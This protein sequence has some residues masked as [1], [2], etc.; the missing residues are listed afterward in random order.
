MNQD[1]ISNKVKSKDGKYTFIEEDT[2]KIDKSF[3]KKNIGDGGACVPHILRKS[4]DKNMKKV[5][6][7]DITTTNSKCNIIRYFFVIFTFMIMNIIHMISFA[8]WI[9]CMIGF[10]YPNGQKYPDEELTNFELFILI[11]SNFFTFFTFDPCAYIFIP[12]VYTVSL[13]INI[14]SNLKYNY[15]YYIV[16]IVTFIA[17]MILNIYQILS[18]LIG[19]LSHYLIWKKFAWTFFTY[20]LG[21]TFVWTIIIFIIIPLLCIIYIIYRMVVSYKL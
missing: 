17:L 14:K 21:K 15:I 13:L 6:K 4:F 2:L 18:M 9:L 10:V 20:C 8:I 1:N 7:K 12:I 16:I 3:D 19:M 5:S 11:I